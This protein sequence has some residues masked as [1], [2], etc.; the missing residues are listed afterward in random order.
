MSPNLDVIDQLSQYGNRV[1]DGV[2]PVR[3][4]D[5]LRT[6]TTSASRNELHPVT[7]QPADIEEHEA[8]VTPLPARRPPAPWLGIAAGVLVVA[9]VGGAITVA[10]G[11][12]GGLGTGSDDSVVSTLATS[13]VDDPPTLGDCPG[14]EWYG[15]PTDD[16]IAK[17]EAEG[18]EWRIAHEDGEDFTLA[19][20]LRDRRVDFWITNGIVT[21]VHI[22]SLSAA[23]DPDYLPE[24]VQ[25]LDD[26]GYLGL[27]LNDAM[28]QSGQDGLT[29]CEVTQPNG[30]TPAI[31]CEPPAGDDELH[32]YV[33][34]AGLVIAI[35]RR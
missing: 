4:A 22:E 16:A 28:Y 8:Y 32:L 15:L 11:G 18:R 34:E 3:A 23:Y 2:K 5:V 27:T 7:T 30:Q 9:L 24:G 35:A 10:R 29:T 26:T 17:A 6:A 19:L 1:G 14:C 31:H 33:D 12:D 13:V 20:D 25:N 21:F